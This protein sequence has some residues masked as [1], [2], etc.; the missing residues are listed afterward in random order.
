MPLAYHSDIAFEYH[1][2]LE[3]G[4]YNL[5]VEGGTIYR[6]RYMI[7]VLVRAFVFSV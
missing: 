5:V 4:S 2:T 7:I 3:R 6:Y 1:M